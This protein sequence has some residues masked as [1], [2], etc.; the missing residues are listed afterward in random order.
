M[1]DLHIHTNVQPRFLTP[2]LT[3]LH[4]QDPFTVITISVQKSWNVQKH[5]TSQMWAGMAGCIDKF[6]NWHWALLKTG[7]LLNF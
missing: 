3:A 5:M 6:G 1:N 4:Q 7:H 2:V